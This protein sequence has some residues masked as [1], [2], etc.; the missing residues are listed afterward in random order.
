V[1][2][3]STATVAVV[4]EEEARKG[5]LRRADM[6]RLELLAE[7]AAW[8]VADRI[9]L[10][11]LVG[12]LVALAVA[13]I[14]LAL[15]GGEWQTLGITLLALVLVCF[16]AWAV[17][18]IVII[19]NP[20]RSRDWRV[21]KYGGELVG[22]DPTLILSLGT[23][24]GPNSRLLEVKYVCSVTDPDGRVWR[25]PDPPDYHATHRCYPGNFQGA[26]RPK[27][28][29]YQVAWLQQQYRRLWKPLVSYKLAV[30]VKGDDG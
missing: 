30:T 12:V 16:L 15:I 23:R 7:R 4:N 3:A 2:S 27:D 8:N 24:G 18:L 20:M 10:H 28:G 9:G 17:S 21:E 25:S 1:L 19:R 29:I 14:S 6:R 5:R 26:P 11:V 13:A 22:P